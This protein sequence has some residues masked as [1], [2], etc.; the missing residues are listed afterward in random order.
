MPINNFTIMKMSHN[1]LRAAYKLY[2]QLD[3][4][5]INKGILKLNFHK[6]HELYIGITW[7]YTSSATFYFDINGT[8]IL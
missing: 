8:F 4:N 6:P 3:I 1:S 7:I 2:Y 5:V